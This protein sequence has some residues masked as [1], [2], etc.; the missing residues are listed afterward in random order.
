MWLDIAQNEDDW[1][2]LRSGKVTGSKIASIMANDGKAFGDPAK[3]LAVDLAVEQI[4]G[5]HVS[6]GYS[7][8]HTERGHEQEPI[9]R[10][11]YENEYFCTVTNGGFYDNGL[12]GCS[13]DGHVGT[14]GLIEIK[15]VIPSRQYKRIKAK[16]FDSAY[17]WQLIF[18]LR[19]SGK[20]WIDYISYCADFP[21]ND[22]LFVR[23]V[24]AADQAEK[25]DRVAKRL[26]TFHD[27]VAEIKSDI[28]HQEA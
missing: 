5:K 25:F 13:P 14:D 24:Y 12:S 2:I 28:E 4:T 22:Q 3:K 11:V 16:T 7:N 27:L 9:A 8:G 1:L 20:E 6:G 17:Q 21:E 26:A 10:M 23:R 18:N 15:C 19:E